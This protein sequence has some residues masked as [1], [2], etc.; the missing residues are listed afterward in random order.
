[1]KIDIEGGEEVLFEGDVEWLRLTK[2]V[3]MEVHPCFGIDERKIPKILDLDSFETTLLN[4]GLK[5]VREL[6]AKGKGYLRGKHF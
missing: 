4:K 1:M 6:D 3:S 2:E 5:V